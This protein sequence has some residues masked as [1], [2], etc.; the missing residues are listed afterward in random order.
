M[1]FSIPPRVLE[2]KA[3]AKKILDE[4]VFPLE[5]IAHDWPAVA[6]KLEAV[7]DHVRKEGLFCPQMG[8]EY[9]GMGLSFLEH[10]IFSEE[11]G[12]SPLGHFVFNCQAPDAG[13]M[14]LLHL[15]GTDEQKH[16]WLHPL[17]RGE[18]RSCFSMT[19]PER[20]GSNPTWLDTRAHHS[21]G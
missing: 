20:A 6:P 21:I 11:L 7:R 9:G 8:T 10:A 19:E 4:H 5:P 2:L 17:A 16:T 14:E 15:F 13:N 3:R 18:I 1:D 12:R